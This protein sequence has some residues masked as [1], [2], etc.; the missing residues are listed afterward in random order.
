MS[1]EDSKTS[2]SKIIILSLIFLFLL[3]LAIYLFVQNNN[4]NAEIIAL[5]NSKSQLQT[6][7]TS[8]T[9]QHATERDQASSTIA[10]LTETLNITQEELDQTE[11]D[12][13]DEENRNEEFEDQIRSL[14]G[15][16]TDLDK[17]SKTDKEL[18]Q[19]YSRTYF[20]NENFVPL[21]LSQIPSKYIMPDKGDKYFHGNAISFLKDLLDDAKKAGYDIRVISAYRS[22]EEQTNLK[23]QYLQVYGSGSNAFS[24]DQGYSEHQLGTTLDIVDIDT[25]TTAQSFAITDAYKWLQANAYRYGFVLSYPENNNF[26][27]FEPWHWRFV[28]VDLARDLHRADAQFYQWD[29]RKIDEY[30]I[31]IFD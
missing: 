31:K 23:G 10:G 17:L 13:R 15:T 14:T 19:K 26:Y 2:K 3:S 29:Q 28:G 16:V 8:L 5:Q 11:E 9:K 1:T 24:A 7:I 6:E 27:V 21:K 4:K 18:L 30:L 12:L 25:R 20:L 22:F